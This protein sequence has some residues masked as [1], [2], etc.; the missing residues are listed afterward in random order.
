M[1]ARQLRERIIP[2]NIEE[3]MKAS[4]IDYSMSVIVSRAL[5]DLRDG[6]KPSHRRILVAMNDLRLTPTSSFRKCAKIAGDTSGNYHP[7]GEQVIYPTLVRMAQEF[8]MRYPLVEGQGNFGSIDGDAPA[9]M[10]YT[11]ARLSPFAMEMLADLEKDTVDFISNYDGTRREPVVLPGKFPHL[12]CNGSSGIA[13]GMATNIPSHNLSEVVG[14]L[15]ALIDDPEIP[16][17]GLRKYIQGPDFPTGGIITGSEGITQAYHTGKGKI[18]LRGRANIERLKG[19]RVNLVVSEIPFQVNKSNLLEDIARLARDK[20]VEGMSELRDESDRE[21]MRI[22]VELKRDAQPEVV[23][24]QLFKHTQ[25]QVTFGIILLFLSDGQPKVMDL[26]EMLNLFLAHRHQVITRKTNFELKKAEE[27]AH[28]LEGLKVAVENIDEVVAIIK[29]SRNPERAKASLMKRF[30]LSD[31]QAQAI[32]DMRLARLTGLEREKIEEEYLEKIKLIAKLKGILE[33][34]AQR[35]G[36]IREELLGLGEKYGDSRRTE[37]VEEEEEFKMEDLIAE[38][39]MAITISHSGYIKR[40]PIS[41]YRR[42]HRGGKGLLGMGTKEEDFV[43]HLFIASTH[44]WLLFFTSQGR[45]YGV[46]VYQLPTGGRLAKGRPIVNLLQVGKEEKVAA[47]VAMS[48]FDPQ[49]FVLLATMEGTIK[50]VGLGDLARPR[51]GGMRVA[52]I[53]E[54]DRLIGAELTDGKAEVI[55]GS[56]LG[57]AVR[58]PETKVRSMGRVARGVRGMQ[59]GKDDWVV[60]MVVVRREADLLVV[61]ENGFGKRTS[62]SNYRVTNRGGKGV[63][64]AK[65]TAKNGPVVSIMEVVESDEIMVATVNGVIIRLKVGGI[66]RCGRASQGVKLIDLAPEDK[67]TDVARVVAE[68]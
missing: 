14:A 49:K 5:P 43:E 38:E 9:A 13:V 18:T 3:E 46:K 30:G 62:I 67:V 41:S 4:Y 24:N 28:V 29:G 22:V 25:L 12:L 21:G 48:D 15:V 54:D 42:Q 6:L 27:R 68:G 55:L 1:M 36:I 44:S 16:I 57:K 45:C 33:S 31:R 32:L 2:V 60:G 7:H 47:S 10:R 59:L 37:I 34:R 35:M 61:T 19:D 8:N 65:I 52:S 53:G 51:R 58:F 17:E 26:K 50:K 64:S 66:R 20:L 11:E 56:R 63:V 23:L 40:L 39:D